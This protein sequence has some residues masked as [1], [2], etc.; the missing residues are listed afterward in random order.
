MPFRGR[1]NSHSISFKCGLFKFYQKIR[2]KKKS[3]ARLSEIVLT[4]DISPGAPSCVSIC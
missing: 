1:K 2:S 3:L 4:D